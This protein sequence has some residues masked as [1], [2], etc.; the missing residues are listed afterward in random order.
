MPS[1]FS[2]GDPP[3]SPMGDVGYGATI[4]YVFVRCYR[5]DG[6]MIPTLETHVLDAYD[7]RNSKL[8][9]VVCWS[10][11]RTALF[12][13]EPCLLA[14]LSC[15]WTRLSNGATAR[16]S[17]CRCHVPAHFKPGL[18]RSLP[19]AHKSHVIFAVPGLQ[20]TSSRTKILFLILTLRE[21]PVSINL[22]RIR[23]ISHEA[24]M[25]S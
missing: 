20:F 9:T 10:D 8:Q 13:S 24:R 16:S 2:H 1:L 19:Q 21:K 17:L 22:K 5:D 12:P 23:N 15:S 18:A 25:S 14:R 6:L 11:K 7:H 4:L 3:S